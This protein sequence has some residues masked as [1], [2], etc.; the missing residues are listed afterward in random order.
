VLDLLLRFLGLPGSRKRAIGNAVDPWDLSTRLLRLSKHDYLTIGRA[1]EGILVQGA[2]GSGKTTGSG[3]AIAMPFLKNGWGGLILCAKPDERRMWE[4]YCQ[5]AGRSD[6]LIIFSPD[7]PW[8]FNFL[9]FE[10]QRKGR[11][12]GLTQNLVNLLSTIAEITKRDAGKGG[13]QDDGGYWE[14]SKQQLLRNLMD[15][16]IFAKGRITVSDLYNVLISAP[17]SLAQKDS[18]EWQRESF[19]YQCLAEGHKR[20]KTNDQQEDF[21]VVAKYWLF[22]FAGL[23][24]KTRSIVAST[25]TS[26]TDVM[27]RGVLRKLFCKETNL[28]P[29]AIEDGKIIIVDLPVNEFAEVGRYAAAIWKYCFQIS[30]TRREVQTSPR[31]VFLWQDEGQNFVLST[32]NMFQSI[33]RSF[34]V[35]TVVLT[36]NISSF[37]ATMGNPQT[38]KALVDSLFGNLNT[39]IFHANGDSVTNIWAADVIGKTPQLLINASRSAQASNYFGGYAET[40]QSSQHSAGVSEAYEYEIPPSAFT[41]LRTGGSANNCIVDAIVFSLG[42]GFRATGRQYMRCAF[43]Q[44]R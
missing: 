32:D 18:A 38:S 31:P 3:R 37:Y 9:D 44:R 2:T 6:D 14:D 8:R 41:S 30:I 5:E 11:G 29:Q 22:A 34:K 24:E 15:L 39:K 17:T 25:F 16:I 36:Q 21:D 7:E 12:A 23:A 26:M 40:G 35:S 33:C 10:L 13:G 28:T 20:P 42:P 4:Q 19:C 43:S 27:N 1:V